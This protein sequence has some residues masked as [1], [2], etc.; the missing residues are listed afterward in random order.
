MHDKLTDYPKTTR[1]NDS[2]PQFAISR[3][4]QCHI[5]EC[6]MY[7]GCRGWFILT[8]CLVHIHKATWKCTCIYWL[9]MFMA[10]I[11]CSYILFTCRILIM[12]SYVLYL[13]FWSCSFFLYLVANHVN[14]FYISCK[15]IVQHP[16]FNV[17]DH[18]QTTACWY[19][20]GIHSEQCCESNNVVKIAKT[21]LFLSWFIYLLTY[22]KC[23]QT[24]SNSLYIK[25]EAIFLLQWSR[26][27]NAS[28]RTENSDQLLL[29]IFL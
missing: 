28:Q 24:T 14:Y 8:A 27:G 2:N 1:I 6:C 15:S 13:M 20:F 17:P 19:W 12:Y 29:F 5:Y 21:L 4:N 25:F 3:N 9:L 23:T 18:V 26:E 11:S 10:F 16:R 7:S 22:F